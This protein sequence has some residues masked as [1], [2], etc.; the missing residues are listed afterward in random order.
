MNAPTPG[1]RAYLH[2]YLER[3][4]SLNLSPRT[5]CVIRNIVEALLV[6]LSRTAHIHAAEQLRPEH[7]DAWL[8]HLSAHR[9]TR[10]QP[11][12]PRSVNKK[13]ECVRGFLMSL[14]RDGIIAGALPERLDY[15]KEPR[16]LPG[17]VLTDEQVR[18]LFAAV[19]TGTPA[20]YRDRVMLEV[21]YSSGVRAGELLGMKVRDVDL[22]NGT[23][24]VLGK[25]RKERMVPLGQT[26]MRMIETYLTAVRPELA[27]TPEEPRLFVDEQ[28]RPYP[29]HSLRRR[30]H[31]YATRAGLTVRVTPHTFRRSC[32]TE[33]LRAGA[34]MYHIKEMLGHESLNTLRHYARLTIMDLKKT[35]H[36]CHP[37]EQAEGEPGEAI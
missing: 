1:L 6:W 35:H 24:R 7:L 20:G 3:R 28:G 2:R 29:Y 19:D 33:M 25:G 18:V 17:S 30:V 26:A 32:A 13:I 23:A 4:R 31:D 9:T 5:L 21:L 34:N 36:L 14:A 22:V 11:L 27:R 16:L 10:N 15:L 12:R 8:A 37:R